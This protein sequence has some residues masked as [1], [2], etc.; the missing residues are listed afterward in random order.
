LLAVYTGSTVSSLTVAGSDDDAFPG[1]P[2][3]F[4]L[5]NQPV[6]ANIPYSIAVDGY[7]G[8]SGTAV[9]TYSFTPATLVHVSAGVQGSGTVQLATVNQLGGKSIQ[10]TTTADVAAGTT[11]V[12]TPVPGQDFRFDSWSGGVTSFSSPLSLVVAN[13]LSITAH[14][15]PLVFSDDFE[16]GTLQHLGWITLGDAPWAVEGTNVAAGQF[17]A[18]S[19][20]VANNQSSSLILTT[21]FASSTGSF[22]YRV[23]SELNFD[24]LKFFIDGS[25]VQKWSG[26]AGWTTFSFPVPSGIHTLQ[27]SYVKD[28]SGKSGLDGAFIDNVNL[29]IVLPKDNT[30]PGRLSLVQGSDGS[31]SISIS[32]QVNQQYVLQTST[33]LIHWQNVSSATAQ[34]GLV[35]FNPGPLSGSAQFFRAVVP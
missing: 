12:L 20:I 18:R 26:A 3:G 33:D 21:N 2:G 11:V 4:S 15:V 27:W 31:L 35:R 8:A 6:H 23:S 25:L 1:A 32:G 28:P 14:F 9:L 30:T 17:A 24:F 29:P 5:L 16:S 22:D 10:P 19:G 34:N 7:G 13:N